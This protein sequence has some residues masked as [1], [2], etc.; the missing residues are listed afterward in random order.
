MSNRCPVPGRYRAARHPSIAPDRGRAGG[1]GAPDVGQRASRLPRP[2]TL[3]LRGRAVVA[4]IDAGSA[5]EPV[6]SGTHALVV[7]GEVSVGLFAVGLRPRQ[8]RAL[9]VKPPGPIACHADVTAVVA[10][11]RR[12][13]KRTR[14]GHVDELAVGAV[15]E[16]GRAVARA[17]LRRNRSGGVPPGRREGCGSDQDREYDH[18]RCPAPHDN[19]ISAHSDR[20][21]RKVKA[22]GERPTAAKND[23]CNGLR[24]AGRAAARGHPP[25]P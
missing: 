24:G 11:D 22:S 18:Q 16:A 10:A 21:P 5:H 19:R 12:F 15:P 3:G 2:P 25:G 23:A 6:G 14:T 13:L 9:T 20:Q 8:K 4:G 1:R 7:L 17:G